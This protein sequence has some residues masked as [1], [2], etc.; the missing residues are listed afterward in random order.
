M[1]AAADVVVHQLAEHVK[2]NVTPPVAASLGSSSPT[3]HPCRPPNSQMI[4]M[5]GSG[6]PISHNNNARPIRLLQFKSPRPR[7]SRIGNVLSRLS[8]REGSRRS[9]AGSAA[10]EWRP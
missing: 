4:R 1:L 7:R 10:A 9:Q 8:F 5:I 6:I 2:Q 3:D